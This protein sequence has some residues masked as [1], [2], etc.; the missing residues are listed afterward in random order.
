MFFFDARHVR[1][2]L[3]AKTPGT[4]TLAPDFTFPSLKPHV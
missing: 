3:L 2:G 4:T 1:V